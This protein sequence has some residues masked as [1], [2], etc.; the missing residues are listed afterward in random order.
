M[1][2]FFS[3]HRNMKFITYIIFSPKSLYKNLTAP[4]ANNNIGSSRL[5]FSPYANE[6]WIFWSALLFLQCLCKYDIFVVLMIEFMNYASGN[7]KNG[8][9][10]NVC[11]STKLSQFRPR[12]S[13]HQMNPINFKF[14]TWGLLLC[15][16]ID[17]P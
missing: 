6:S 1:A 12:Y 16:I 3:C 14:C 15:V 7:S 8:V 11:W 2:C 4:S 9:W 5:R 10:K 17:S 13:V